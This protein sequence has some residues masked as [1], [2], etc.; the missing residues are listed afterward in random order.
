MNGTITDWSLNGWSTTSGGA[1]GHAPPGN[2]DT[3][4]FDGN[5]NA[6]N[7]VT[8]TQATQVGA[9][10][11]TSAW[12]K[13][14]DIKTNG[15]LQVR[16]LNGSNNSLLAGGDI[17]QAADSNWLEF[18]AGDGSTI[19]VWT[20]TRIQFNT[21]SPSWIYIAT[22]FNVNGPLTGLDV[23]NYDC[24]D[25]LDIGYSKVN[26]G[27]VGNC[28]FYINSSVD[29]DIN[30]LGSGVTPVWQ[31]EKSPSPL[32]GNE[33]YFNTIHS[34]K[35]YGYINTFDLVDCGA[36]S[37]TIPPIYIN[38]GGA[39][40]NG[41]GSTVTLGTAT[42]GQ[43][44][45]SSIYTNGTITLDNG[46]TLNVS[47][48]VTQAGGA[49][50]LEVGAPASGNTS[51]ATIKCSSGVNL[52]F[53][54]GSVVL[55]NQHAGTV[56]FPTL[57]INGASG[58]TFQQNIN[59]TSNIKL[60]SNTQANYGTISIDTTTSTVWSNTANDAQTFTEYTN[61][62]GFNPPGGT[63]YKIITGSFSAGSQTGHTTA[64]FWTGAGS[65]WNIDLTR[66]TLDLQ[67]AYLDVQ[68][69]RHFLPDF[70][71]ALLAA[72]RQSI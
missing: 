2:T 60:T 32:Q 69:S 48:T 11:L 29:H 62:N 26:S 54:N 25:Y 15:T 59:L 13:E 39:F 52:Y 1:G 20:G 16:G 7:N 31:L 17:E 3:A 34:V 8:I 61:Y 65:T 14:L 24:H 46:S 35:N 55:G 67:S 71:F 18:D 4:T 9:I 22:P 37:G 51:H 23:N 58:V 43:V 40:E 57:Y 36:E 41:G 38:S 21:S 72:Q 27:T 10:N 19:P 64:T 70:Y 12:T 44:A 68:W 45:N 66:I 63:L 33:I 49:A 30:L 5:S 28:L 6:V 47:G 42:L 56:Y 50:I 53:N